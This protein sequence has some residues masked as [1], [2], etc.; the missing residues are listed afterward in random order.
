[1]EQENIE[2][3]LADTKF[4]APYDQRIVLL[5]LEKNIANDETRINL[6]NKPQW[7]LEISPKGE[8]PVMRINNEIIVG[9]FNI[10]CFIDQLATPYFMPSVA[11]IY[12]RFI[13]TLES[14]DNFGHELLMFFRERK[15]TIPDLAHLN[16]FLTSFDKM[17]GGTYLLGNSISY[18][19]LALIPHML[20]VQALEELVFPFSMLAKHQ[21]LLKWFKLMLKRQS[22][23][24]TSQN[25]AKYFIEHLQYRGFYTQFF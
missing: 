22:V 25:H 16:E 21:N 9:S 5:C 2:L 13:A 12:S 4:Y 17:L 1:M 18:L 24:L 11:K 6:Q 14:F 23:Q 7:F 19:D 15:N 8:V 3:I 10:A 20:Q